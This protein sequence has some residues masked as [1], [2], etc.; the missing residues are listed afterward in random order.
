MDELMSYGNVDVQWGNHDVAWMG[1]AAGSEVCMAQVVRT[2]VHYG[3]LEV[4]E[5]SYGIS[6]RELAL[7]ADAT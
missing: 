1:A 7:F 4:L 5:N 3:T 6:L 2:C